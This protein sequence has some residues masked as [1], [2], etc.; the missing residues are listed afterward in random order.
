MAEFL[1]AGWTLL[2]ALALTLF[3]GWII[4]YLF[5]KK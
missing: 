3:A 5:K 2:N 4:T 1:T